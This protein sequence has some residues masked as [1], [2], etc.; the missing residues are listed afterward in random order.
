MENR[1]NK[2]TKRSRN[3][4]RITIAIL[5]EEIEG[6]VVAVVGELVV[7]GSELL[8]TL[9]RNRRKI[10]GEFCVLC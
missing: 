10:T 1:L 4:A 8:K 2:K 9:R 7:G 6:V 5:D 3:G